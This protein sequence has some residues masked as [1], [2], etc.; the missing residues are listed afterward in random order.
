[1]REHL[2]ARLPGRRL[3]FQV[4]SRVERPDHDGVTR[5]DGD[6]GRVI[7]AEHVGRRPR[8]R[9]EYVA[10]HGHLSSRTSE[11]DNAPTAGGQAAG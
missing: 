10:G 2:R 8:G 1:M 4:A 3:T 6:R 11:S 7:R 9:V 5:V